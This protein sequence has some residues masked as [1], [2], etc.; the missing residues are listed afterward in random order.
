[1]APW[2]RLRDWGLMKTAITNAGA[3]GIII[4]EAKATGVI[5][6]ATIIKIIMVTLVWARII[7]RKRIIPTF[8]KGPTGKTSNP[9][10]ILA[11]ISRG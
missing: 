10:E 4:T 5:K 1:M 3:S 8:P 11:R 9:K 6:G 2:A 7:G